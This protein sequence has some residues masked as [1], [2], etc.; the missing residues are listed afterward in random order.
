MMKA[1]VVPMARGLR[2][3]GLVFWVSKKSWTR[4]SR[5]DEG[6]RPTGAGFFVTHGAS[7]ASPNV[8]VSC[9]KCGWSSVRRSERASVLDR[10]AAFVFLSPLRCRKCRLRFYRPWYIASRALPLET[11]SRV[12]VT[13]VASSSVPPPVPTTILLVDDDAALRKLFRRLLNKEGHQVHEISNGAA[14]L[15]E[16][17]A[18]RAD[19]ALVNL[20]AA[21]AEGRAL[22]A[23]RTA[24]PE[25]TIVTLSEKRE[26]SENLLILPKLSRPLAVV[27]FVA[28]TLDAA[29]RAEPCASSQ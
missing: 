19:L 22:Q 29:E 6:V 13:V 21:E 17:G 10:A 28:Q 4:G 20:S 25:L 7:P 1:G 18:V 27:A 12:P 5:A 16:L 14:A 26:P 23:L 3:R 8:R 2:I 11:P 15:A 24:Y 9:P